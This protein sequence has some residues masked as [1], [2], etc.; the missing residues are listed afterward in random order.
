MKTC[1]CCSSK[2]FANCCAP[3]LNASKTP[4]LP[5]ELMRSRYSAYVLH[6]ADYLV[7][8]THVSQRKNYPKDAILEWA[9]ANTWLKLEVLEAKDV[10]VTFKAYYLENNL[11]AQV[12]YE[13]STFMKEDGIWYY[14]DGVFY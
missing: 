2:S 7:K 9:Q 11:K 3:F 12:H 1:Y 6:N 10:M 14:V 13:K 5:E 4:S 8:T